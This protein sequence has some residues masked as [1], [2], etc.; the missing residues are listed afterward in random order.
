MVFHR[1]LFWD[2][3][4]LIYIYI[5]INDFPNIIKKLCH[6][7]L[8][9][10]DTS[11]LVTS[12]NYIELNRKLNSTL[13]H[14]SRWFQTNKLVLNA[15]IA[16]I[17]TFTS[18][19]ATLHPRNRIHAAR[20]LAVVETIKFLGFYLDSHLSWLSNINVLLKKLRFVYFM[21]RKLSYVLNIET[22]KVA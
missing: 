9:A 22:L 3:C 5:Y 19:K 10:D 15:N 1:A 16:C 12:T 7:L 14:V 11:V 18:S 8:F 21:M 4:C 17:G 20:I 6:S 2:S 13:H